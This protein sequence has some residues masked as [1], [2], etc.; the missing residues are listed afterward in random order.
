MYKHAFTEHTKLVPT[1]APAAVQEP[2][3]PAPVVAE[4]RKGLAGFVFQESFS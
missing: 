2:H 4:K 1:E 3:T